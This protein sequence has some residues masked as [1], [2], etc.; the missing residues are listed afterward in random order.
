AP[1][2]RELRPDVPPALAD[3]VARLLAKSPDDRFPTPADAATALQSLPAGGPPAAL[4][5]RGPP[6]DATTGPTV[7]PGLSIIHEST[8]AGLPRAPLLPRH[9]WR[10]LSAAV[11]GLVV[12]LV[13]LKVAGGRDDT[14]RKG[15]AQVVQGERGTV[16]PQ[17]QEN[18]PP[19][20]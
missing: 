2:I 10:A 13:L 14:D 7:T 1:P 18:E 8:T 15:E 16:V 11:A 6:P 9:R 5:E 19:K 3:V 20:V 4:S 17:G 12:L